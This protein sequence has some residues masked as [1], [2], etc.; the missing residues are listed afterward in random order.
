MA[1]MYVP[2]ESVELP[3]SDILNNRYFLG[4]SGWVWVLWRVMELPEKWDNPDVYR[5]PEMS[6]AADGTILFAQTALFMSKAEALAH[7]E[8]N[9]HYHDI[10]GDSVV[11]V[12]L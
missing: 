2:F 11:M 7:V 3:K 12:E 5:T 8:A 6:P 9:R 4:R 1:N 10:L